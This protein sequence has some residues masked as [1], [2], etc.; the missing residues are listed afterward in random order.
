[1]ENTVKSVIIIGCGHRGGGYARIMARNRDKFKVVA[2]AEPIET[3][4]N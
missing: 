2:V 4:R 1:M 3:V